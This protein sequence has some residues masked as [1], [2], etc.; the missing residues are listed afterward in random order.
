MP[1]SK[2]TEM[3]LLLMTSCVLCFATGQNISEVSVGNYIYVIHHT[4]TRVRDTAKSAC[5]DNNAELVTIDSQRI[6]TALVETILQYSS[7]GRFTRSPE[8]FSYLEGRMRSFLTA[9]P[10]AGF[11]LVSLF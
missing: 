4:P 2:F 3:F 5:I 10:Y 9:Y 1:P 7:D 11:K 6:M 8:I